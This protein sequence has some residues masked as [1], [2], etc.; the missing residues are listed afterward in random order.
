MRLCQEG[1]GEEGDYSSLLLAAAAVAA[2][3]LQLGL[4]PLWLRQTL[5][6]KKKTITLDRSRLRN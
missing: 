3:L 5:T 6:V 4:C 1:E 2:A